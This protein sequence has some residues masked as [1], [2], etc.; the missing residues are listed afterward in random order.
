M[1]TKPQKY[2][3]LR[4]P[5]KNPSVIDIIE[6]GP[7]A[8]EVRVARSNEADQSRPTNVLTSEKE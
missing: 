5:Q 7:I 6:I 2:T 4:L 8:I 3:D 1:Q